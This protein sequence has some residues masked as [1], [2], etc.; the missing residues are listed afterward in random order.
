MKVLDKDI[1]EP[2]FEFLEEKYGKIRIFEEKQMGKSRADVVMVLDSFLYGI[3]IKSDAD[4]YARL[5]RQV[6]DYNRYYDRN[7]VC[8]GASHGIHIAEHV[9]DWWGIIT[10]EATDDGMDFY[11][12]REPADNPKSNLK[13]KLGFLWR[14]EL[15]HILEINNLPAYKGKSKDF[16]MDKLVEKIAEDDLRIC[17]TNELFE[18]DYTKLI[19][20]I[21]AYRASTGRRPVRRRRR[22]KR[23]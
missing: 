15:N 13:L 4:T 21:N 18:R 1:R 16:V 17:L 14:P 19:N 2:L 5:T 20:E 7:I 3:E 11:I 6:K 10:V 12:L 8:V 9:P 22:C 23:K